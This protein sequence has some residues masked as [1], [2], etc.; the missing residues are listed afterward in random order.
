M[1]TVDFLLPIAGPAPFLAE[2][3]HSIL[4]QTYPDWRLVAVLDGPD[5]GIRQELTKLVPPRQ[6]N[7]VELRARSGLCTALNAGIEVS[8]AAFLARIDADDVNLKDR[9]SIQLAAAERWPASL[10]IGGSAVLIDESGAEVGGIEVVS[11]ADVRQSLLTR[12]AIV[13]SSALI[14]REPL[15]AVG[16]YNLQCPLRE[17][18]ELW[19]RLAAQG[20]VGNVAEPVVRYRLSSGQVSR[21][22]P[23]K[24][25]IR[26]VGRARVGAARAIGAP[27]AGARLRQAAWAAMQSPVAQRRLGRLRRFRRVDGTA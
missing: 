15:V 5:D 25:S 3:L 10:V 11:G 26:E 7:L 16:G 27:V 8:E 21:R 22:T 17:D 13:H 20:P 14:R 4:D 6:L 18:Y 19:L 2:T 9:L 12:N 1:R 23:P 24:E